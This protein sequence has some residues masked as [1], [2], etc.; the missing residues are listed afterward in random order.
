MKRL[1]IVCSHPI[2]YYAPLFQLM[3]KSHDIKVFYSSSSKHRSYDRG[4]NVNVAW[5]IPLLEG[6]DYEFSH[7]ISSIEA[8]KATSILIYGWAFLSHLRIIR[9]F[10][11]RVPLYFRGDSTLINQASRGKAM[12]KSL[13]LKYV[14]AHVDFAFYV[15]TN[16]KT[17]FQQYGLSVNQLIYVPHAVDNERFSAPRQSE[18]M[19][20][21]RN[22]G[23]KEDEL[24]ILFT[25]KLII[26][27]NPHL[28]LKAFVALNYPGIHL[29]FVGSGILESSI[30]ASAACSAN[31]Q[32]IHFLPFQN[33]QQMPAIY[34]SCD[35]FCLPSSGPGES[36]GLA[37]NEAMAAGKPILASNN[38]GATLD[39]VCDAN[40]AV[41]ESGNLKDLTN[42][43]EVLLKCKNC[44]KKK[45][46]I[47]YK[48]IQS[49]SFQHQL[50]AIYAE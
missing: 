43:L 10:N 6:Y 11:K 50:K 37:I 47:S 20:I 21:R 39:L 12:I 42:K 38:A 29:L 16:N 1:A 15:G 31:N 14:Y 45:G 7:S 9:H 35:L 26:K 33:Q 40:G 41:F 27:K 18:A 32:N 48:T 8:Y 36:W 5:D 17:Y 46:A 3:A 34:Q 25:G 30:K 19:H 13:W 23:I 22:F 4:F 44:L 49:W 24:L 28:L 2:Q